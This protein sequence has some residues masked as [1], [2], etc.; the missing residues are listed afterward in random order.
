MQ[1]ATLFTD[2]IATFIE[3]CTYRFTLLL[4]I[5]CPLYTI[6]LTPKTYSMV[7]NKQFTVTNGVNVNK[8]TSCNCEY[9]QV[10]SS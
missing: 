3:Y 10:K 8:F 9:K 7:C 5:D 4:L 6:S 1:N 2:F